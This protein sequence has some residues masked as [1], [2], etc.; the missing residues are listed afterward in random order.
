[1]TMTLPPCRLSPGS[2]Y[3][4]VS[5]GTGD[6]FTGF[7]DFDIVTETLFFDV[8][9]EINECGALATWHPNWGSIIFGQMSAA[10]GRPLS[11]LS[12]H[13]RVAPVR[14]HRS[15]ARFGIS[16]GANTTHSCPAVDN[17]RWMP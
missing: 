15:P 1:M 10:W 4:D 9:P 2:Y 11:A 7:E 12:G 6:L 14:L 17:C 13:G 5:I 3:C 16:D 8:M